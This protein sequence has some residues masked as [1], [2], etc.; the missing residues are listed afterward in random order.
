MSRVPPTPALVLVDGQW[1]RGTVRACLTSAD[2]QTCSAVVSYGAD[3][4]CVTTGRFPASQI[5]GLD[6]TPGCPAPHEDVSC[7]PAP[8][9]TARREFSLSG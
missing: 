5:R 8:V 3:P 1:V 7:C 9:G 6:E 4:S 2:G